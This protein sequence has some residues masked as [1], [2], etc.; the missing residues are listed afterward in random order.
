[1]EALL[2]KLKEAQKTAEKIAEK[3]DLAK[4]Q[5]VQ[6]VIKTPAKVNLIRNKGPGEMTMEE[7]KELIAEL[8][9]QNKYKQDLVPYQEKL[10]ELSKVHIGT[11]GTGGAA[12]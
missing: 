3:R 2:T 4:K 11:T 9:G 6:T 8:A 7:I 5:K 12:V 10:K 1:V